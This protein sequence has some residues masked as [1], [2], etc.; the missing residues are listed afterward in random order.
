MDKYNSLQFLFLMKLCF[1]N[2][3]GCEGFDSNRA[4]FEFRDRITTWRWTDTMRE[5]YFFDIDDEKGETIFMI[6]RAGWEAFLHWVEQI[7]DDELGEHKESRFD[8]FCSLKT[9]SFAPS[10]FEEFDGKNGIAIDHLPTEFRDRL[11][12]WSQQDLDR[13][14]HFF[15]IADKKLAI[16]MQGWSMFVMWMGRAIDAKLRIDQYNKIMEIMDEQNNRPTI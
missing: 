8:E 1:E 3:N 12:S 14:R 15:E 16:D 6:S 10:G 11:M 9:L 2:F 13:K 5:G 4:P 7:M